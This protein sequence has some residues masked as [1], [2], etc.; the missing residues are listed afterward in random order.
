MSHQVS[1]TEMSSQNELEDLQAQGLDGWML[2]PL[3]ME[4]LSRLLA[5][6]LKD[7]ND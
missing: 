7:Y 3:N 5:R 2:K 6:V 1:E 4:Q